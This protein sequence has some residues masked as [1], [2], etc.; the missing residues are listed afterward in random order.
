MDW[1]EGAESLHSHTQLSHTLRLTLKFPP[2]TQPLWAGGE[3][4]GERLWCEGQSPRALGPLVSGVAPSC[5]S[6]P[7]AWQRLAC[8]RH[9]G[10]LAGR[11]R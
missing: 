10:G 5:S 9:R 6:P 4:W 8:H 3:H 2:Y 7:R 1:T 11:D